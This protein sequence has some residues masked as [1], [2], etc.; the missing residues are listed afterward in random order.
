M[1][2]QQQIQ[3]FTSVAS[4]TVSFSDQDQGLTKNI[5]VTIIGDDTPEE[6]ETFTVTLTGASLGGQIS[7]T[8]GSAKGR[9]T[10]DDGSLL[11]IVDASGAEG[12]AS[13]DGSGDGK[14]N[15]YCNTAFPNPPAELT[16]TWTVTEEDGANAATETD[17]YTSTTG[18]VRILPSQTAGT[19]ATGTFDVVTKGDDIPE[20]DE[21]FTV[22]LSNPSAGAQLSDQ[23]QP[24]K[25]T[26]F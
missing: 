20:F 13:A 8:A 12:A 2:L 21:T 18:T 7:T 6:D 3:I 5:E 11:T 15:I 10:N 16:A 25:G 4:G 23:I 14:V 9:I 19:P 17:D 1:I 22:T 26:I 24:H